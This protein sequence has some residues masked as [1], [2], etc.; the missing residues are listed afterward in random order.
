MAQQSISADA[1]HCC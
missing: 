1:V